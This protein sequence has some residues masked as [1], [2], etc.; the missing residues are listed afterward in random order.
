MEEEVMPSY[1]VVTLVQY[2][3]AS[4]CRQ[5]FMRLQKELSI[6]KV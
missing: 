3:Y 4:G 2:L 5:A 6:C 1:S